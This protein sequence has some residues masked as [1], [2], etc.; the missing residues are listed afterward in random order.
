MDKKDQATHLGLK[1]LFS[2]PFMSCL[3]ERR[4]RRIARGTSIDAGPL[5]YVSTNQPAAL[6]ELEEAV[7]IVST[8]VTGLA[9]HD[10]PLNRPQGGRELGTPLLNVVAR[11][12]SSPDNCQATSFFMINDE[13]I[14]LLR[15][16]KGRDAVAALKELPPQWSNWTA[17]DWIK[18][19]EAVKVRVSNRR[20]D[21]PREYPYYLGWNKLIS[22]RPGT[23]IF[24]PMVDCTWQYINAILVLL[25]EPDGQR[26]LVIDDFSKF[27]PKGA[28]EI[29]AW[30]GGKLGLS[31]EIPYQ[32]IGGL[33]WIRNAFVSKDNVI[34]LGHGRALRTDYEC[35]LA[36]QNLTLVG[37]ALGLGGWIHSSVNPPYIY[38]TDPAK[39]WYGL[40]FRMMPPKKMSPMP[41]LP[42]AEP[43]PVGIDGVFQALSPPYVGSMDEAVDRVLD[44]KYGERGVY[45]DLSVFSL[46]YRDARNA[47]E[48]VREA[49]HFSDKAVAYAKEICAYIYDTYGRFPAHVDAFYT[50]GIWVQFSHLE[51]EYYDKFFDARQ[52]TRQAQHEAL[53]HAPLREDARERPLRPGLDP[54]EK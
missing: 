12:A 35:F 22:N 4:T 31:D 14:W 10:G 25:S 17:H 46:P 47:Q 39:G 38:E 5:S 42:A 6:S 43:N 40:G 30:L 41:P 28:I 21:F 20:L 9:T 2:Y 53:W 13:G 11:S 51:M 33:K 36:L 34:P 45:G 44:A 3:V 50:P 49:I 26:P 19:S 32:P 29:L 8:G 37:Q 1:N 27:H 48:Y 23:T 15:Q 18:A 24:L 16:P 7:L 54:A 52:Y